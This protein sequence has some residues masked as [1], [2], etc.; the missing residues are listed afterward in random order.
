MGRPNYIFGQFRKTARCRDAQHG[1]CVCCALAPQLVILKTEISWN[2]G[3]NR[4]RNQMLVCNCSE[5]A[6]SI[7]SE[8]S[9]TFAFLRLSIPRLQLIVEQLACGSECETCTQLCAA[10]LQKHCLCRDNVLT[11]PIHVRP[12]LLCS[13]ILWNLR[14]YW[15]N[16][17]ITA[18]LQS[19]KNYTEKS[20]WR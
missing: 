5:A 9:M 14:I 18:R 20:F 7:V 13:E 10:R 6:R 16:T 15:F 19:K 1:V 17:A 12:S 2:F 3:G 11:R 8:P 4:K